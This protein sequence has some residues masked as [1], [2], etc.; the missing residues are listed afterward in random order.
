MNGIFYTPFYFEIEKEDFALLKNP[1]LEGQHCHIPGYACDGSLLNADRIAGVGKG[2]KGFLI[3]S[4][5][6]LILLRFI[7][8]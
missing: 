6:E 4:L 2:S 1:V 7:K 5:I 8:I 3:E